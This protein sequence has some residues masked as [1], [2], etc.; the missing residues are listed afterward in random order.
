[1]AKSKQEV[2]NELTSKDWFPNPLIKSGVSILTD[3]GL[4]INDVIGTGFLIQHG[5]VNYVVTA[6]HVLE[7]S[8][9]PMIGYHQTN[10]DL[11]RVSSDKLSSIAHLE[12]INHPNGLDISAI[13]FS[14]QDYM[15]VQVIPKNDWNL[16]TNM[17]K[18]DLVIHLGHPQGYGAS[19]ANGKLAFFPIAM[20]GTVLDGNQNEIITHTNGQGGA[21]GGPLFLKRD[22]QNPQL[23]G[24]AVQAILTSKDQYQNK[25]RSLPILNVKKILESEPMK[26]QV[27]EFE[28]LVITSL[29]NP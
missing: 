25:T 26:K 29:D 6:K 19:Y 2:P 21:S 27:A 14:V 11:Q 5:K 7:N 24:I 3:P 8:V 17:N 1:M 20:S 13:P 28:K 9:N 12:W 16:P 15:D 22:G 23:I 18:G 4:T 10:G